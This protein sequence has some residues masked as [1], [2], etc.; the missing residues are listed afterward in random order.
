MYSSWLAIYQICIEFLKNLN[1]TRLFFALFNLLL[2]DLESL[3]ATWMLWWISYKLLKNRQM[4][5]LCFKLK[6]WFSLFLQLFMNFY[7]VS[8]SLDFNKFLYGWIDT[9]IYCL[10]I[11]INT[12][13]IISYLRPHDEGAIFL[14]FH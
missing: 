1:W 12:K 5:L 8:I 4:Q 11:F 2:V 10:C 7:I 13:K 9:I 6:C 3:Y 14:K